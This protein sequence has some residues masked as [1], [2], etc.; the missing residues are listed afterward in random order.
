ML[1]LPI[2]WDSLLI[3]VVALTSAGVAFEGPIQE[4]GTT[5]GKVREAAQEEAAEEVQEEA[6]D[7]AEEVAEQEE[8][9][10]AGKAKAK[11][12]TQVRE[13]TRV[14]AR[15]PVHEETDVAVEEEAE[16]VAESYRAKTVLGSKVSIEENISIGTVDDIVFSDEGYVE[17]LIVKNENKLATIPWEAAKFNFEQRTAVVNIT[18]KQYEAVPTYT[19]EKYPVFHAPAYRTQTYQYFGLTPR[20]RRAVRR[21]IDR[22]D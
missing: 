2:R 14:E 3:A 13:S 17:Y 9:E 12:K 16:P 8:E 10:P 22:R 1:S 21:E 18:Q 20:E 5:R 19:Q 15:K 11:T 4:R 6:K 7:V